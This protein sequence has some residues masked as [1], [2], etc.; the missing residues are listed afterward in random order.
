MDGLC[1]S[2]YPPVI[3]E[4]LPPHRIIP[5]VS[6][7]FISTFDVTDTLTGIGARGYVLRRL[8]TKDADR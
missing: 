4:T 1:G 8:H 5:A 3:E 7:V 6:A 2:V